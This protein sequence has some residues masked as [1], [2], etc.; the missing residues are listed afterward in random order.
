MQT[1]LMEHNQTESV[2]GMNEARTQEQNDPSI[3]PPTAL[4]FKHQVIFKFEPECASI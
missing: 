2:A 1:S 3:S 4:I